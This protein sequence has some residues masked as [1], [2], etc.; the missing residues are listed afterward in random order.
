MTD[1][2]GGV[3]AKP[4]LACPACHA[5]SST[6]V[7]IGTGTLKRCTSCHLVYSPEFVDPDHIYVEGYHSGGVEGFGV[8]ITHPAWGEL[9][10]FAGERRMDLLDKL[11]RPPGRLLDVGCGAGHTL[12]A[13]VRRG[14][15]GTG[16]ELVPS[17]AQF[18]VSEFG[19]DVHNSLLEDSGLPP[20]SFD[21]VMANHVLE[22]MEDGTAFLTS[23][24][25]WVK[26]GGYLF[27]EVPNWN[28]VDRRGNRDKWFGYRPL[29]HLAHY[30]PRTLA[31]TLK[32][33]GFTP[34]SVR[35]PFY[36]FD[37]QTMGQALHDLGL[38]RLAPRLNRNALTVPGM[39]RDQ[40]VRLPNATMRR[41]LGLTRRA[42]SSAKAGV[43]LVAVARVP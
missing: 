10:S 9:L 25:R 27:I 23:I 15:E 6:A 19:L 31:A 8:D 30:S 16:V 28:S 22:H 29:E 5:T 7:T 37:R 2:A 26:P 18:A 41:A 43:V 42:A 24:G 35:A 36:E 34:V 39:Q 20:R 17:A 32:R 1:P 40:A 3:R 4:L 13:A 33:A 11:V 14:W 38:S 21:V 12:D